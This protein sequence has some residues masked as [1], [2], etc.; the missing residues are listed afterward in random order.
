LASQEISQL[1]ETV[2]RAMAVNQESRKS[3]SQ[4]GEAGNLELFIMHEITKRLYTA[5][6]MGAQGSANA[7]L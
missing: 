1:K 4:S 7:G 3:R 2:F 5:E 6:E